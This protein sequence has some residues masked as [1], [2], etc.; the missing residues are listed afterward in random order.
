MEN[1][2][3]R[4][5]EGITL[6]F[7]VQ[8][9]TQAV[10]FI[11]GLILARLLFPVEYGLVGMLAIFLSLFE[12]LTDS[13]FGT[14]IIQKKNPSD[15]DYST[16]FWFNF[17]FSLFLYLFLFFLAPVIASFFNEEKLVSILRVL[18][19]S[20][21]LNSFGSIQ[22]K[23]LNKNLQF[24]SLSRVYFISST[25]ASFIAVIFAF[26]G[27]GVWA[28]VIKTLSASMM[29]NLGWW[30]VSSWK[31]R[32]KFSIASFKQLF[33]FGSKI[34]GTG[35]IEV[36][37]N[38]LYSL[39]I[40]RFFSAP[41][42]GFFTRARQFTELP[43]KTIRSTSVNI[44]FSGL[45]HI[46][47]DDTRL[48]NAYKRV[49]S[50]L[51]FVLFPIYA[52]LGVI[53]FPMIKVLLTD[54]WLYCVGYIQVL[55]LIAL[56]FPFESINSNLLY[57]KGKSSIILLLTF[58]RRFIFIIL[59]FLLVRL[60]IIA[61]VWGLVIDAFIITSL[62]IYFATRVI[63]YR[64]IDQFKD[65]LPVLIISVLTLIIMLISDYFL[66]NPYLKLFIIPSLGISFY[67]L[68]GYFFTRENLLEVMGLLKIRGQA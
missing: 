24:K 51:S 49:I 23:Y 33:Q 37:F 2:G 45:S 63:S 11:L 36:I 17:I 22:G 46:Q 35:I 54:K 66:G 12:M 40:G 52:I 25:G 15:L 19:L 9:S 6:G 57:I 65:V 21:I 48:I 58:I 20:S 39:V 47:D 43:D 34:L 59:I 16:V 28:L 50:V 41:E 18:G 8:V 62:N 13:G 32:F 44:L 61:L 7:Y 42:L 26:L 30:I 5:R 64:L 4:T 67:L 14:A 27:Y 29:L 31:P 3:N 56:T 55:C 10:Q 38:N 53:A 60:G 68:L 1:L